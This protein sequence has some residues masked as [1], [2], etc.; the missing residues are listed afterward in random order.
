MNRTATLMVYV[1]EQDVTTQLYYLVAQVL[2][3][4]GFDNTCR[5]IKNCDDSAHN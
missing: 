5:L 3:K 1:D 4:G 2:D